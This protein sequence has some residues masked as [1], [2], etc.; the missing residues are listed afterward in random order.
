MPAAAAGC[1]A[2]AL[3]AA[4]ASNIRARSPSQMMLAPASKRRSVA[5]EASSL[6]CASSSGDSNLTADRK[7]TPSRALEGERV[8][9]VARERRNSH[10]R[11][12]AR[13][14]VQ[15]GELAEGRA[16]ACGRDFAHTRNGD[17]GGA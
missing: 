7:P 5:V 14:I 12:C 16:A 6:F 1:T 10:H 3:S 2:G 4:P 9:G 11:G 17:V 8:D 15:Q 13:S